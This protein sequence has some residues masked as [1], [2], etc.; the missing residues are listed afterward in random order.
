MVRKQTIPVALEGRGRRSDGTPRGVHVEEALTPVA[1]AQARH[2][3]ILLIDD[4]PVIHRALTQRLQRS[5]H[6]ITTAANGQEG[7]LALEACSYDVIFCDMRMP[8]LDGPGFYRELDRRHPHLLV[9]LVFLPGDVLSAEAQ[10]CF[11]Q[12]DRP[13]LV[14]PFKAQEVLQLIRQVLAAR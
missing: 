4:E 2:G 11:A 10:A 13:R 9:R 12:V 1:S 3:T 6:T 14:K 5:G 8:D 7:L